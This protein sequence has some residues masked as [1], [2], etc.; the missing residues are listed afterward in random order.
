MT[1]MEI[2]ENAPEA[3]TPVKYNRMTLSELLQ[4]GVIKKRFEDVL[5][6]KAAGFISSIMS[7]V[8]SNKK[9][10]EAN[11]L[12]VVSAAAI[13]A[14]LDLPIN[15]NLGFAHIVPYG[16]NAQFQ[17]GWR[18]YVQLAMRTGQ[19]R[20]INVEKV[21]EG[22]L[23]KYDR[24][25][26][27]MIFDESK[28]TSDNIAGYVAFFRLLNGFEKYSYMTVKEI[29]DHG[30]KYSKSYSHSDGR[31]KLDFDP[32]A[33]KTVLKLLLNRFG[34]LS[35]SIEKAIQADQ[36]IVTENDEFVYV[37]STTAEEMPQPTSGVEAAKAAF[38]KGKEKKQ[39]ENPPPAMEKPTTK[40]FTKEQWDGI[41]AYGVK[42]SLNDKETQVLFKWAAEQ[43]NLSLR[44]LEAYELMNT[45]DKFDAQF[46]KY[47]ALTE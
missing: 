6:Q 42:K 37:D 9:L 21:Y 34:I 24:F 8:S 4:S 45:Q 32:M 29:Q 22:E 2:M 27:E 3:T 47:L 11:P 23:V 35:I 10:L 17:M 19:Y 31:W 30:K 25:T 16:G 14:S 20:L 44:S 28:K 40:E 41:V 15:P 46:D 26:G 39:T 12:S 1:N 5:G 18:G 43:N 33:K 7:A 36:A 13:A 38:K